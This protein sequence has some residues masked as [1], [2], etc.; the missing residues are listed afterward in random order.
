MDLPK[1]I[2]IYP[3]FYIFL[4]KSVNPEILIFIKLSK[5]SLK[6]KYKIK[7]LLII[8]IKVSNILLSRKDTTTTKIHKNQKIFL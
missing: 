8:M 6:N 7:K 3:I 4:L 1:E 2:K 5:L